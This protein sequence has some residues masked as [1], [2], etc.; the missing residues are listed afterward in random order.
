M[1]DKEEVERD[2][3]INEKENKKI[4]DSAKVVALTA[5]LLLM[6]IILLPIVIFKAA[7]SLIHKML[8]ALIG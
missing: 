2:I 8:E 1:R 6:V 7:S 5:I 3:I 4:S